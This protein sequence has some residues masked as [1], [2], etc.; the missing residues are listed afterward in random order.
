MGIQVE[1][2]M[3]FSGCFSQKSA[4]M[5]GSNLGPYPFNISNSDLYIYVHKVD[6]T[7]NI[8]SSSSKFSTTYSIT[9][10]FNTT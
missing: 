6:Y 9:I 5:V 7:E 8:P 1:W 3:E 10:S 2:K 4:M